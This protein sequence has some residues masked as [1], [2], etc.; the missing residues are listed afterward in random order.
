MIIKYKQIKILYN[1]VFKEKFIYNSMEN[2]ITGRIYILKSFQTENIYIGSTIV[3]IRRRLSNHKADYK[4]FNKGNYHYK[5]SFE[6]AKYDDMYIELIKEVSCTK[7]QLLILEG[8]EI[9]KNPKSINNRIA[10]HPL[11]Y[12]N[13]NEYEK[14][15]IQERNKD[16]VYRNHTK[17]VKKEWND[18]H[19]D[20][21]YI[22]NKEWQHS[23]PEKVKEY[24]RKY[25]N[26]HKEEIKEYNQL[27]KEKHKL[28]MR[29]YRK[30][31]NIIQ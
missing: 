1:K 23:N 26:A 27:N 4:R 11:M 7:N 20:Y 15:R 13:Y 30:N 3:D 19:P 5:S 10:G 8:E 6:I 25:N 2:I 29:E 14:I 18:A 28:Y 24:K 12:D 22:K 16:E 9:I 31:K 17:E 21:H